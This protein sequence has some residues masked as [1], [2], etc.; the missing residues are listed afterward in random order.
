M[1]GK[2]ATAY[3]GSKGDRIT[4]LQLV[5]LVVPPLLLATMR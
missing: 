2:R 5:L 3:Q 1:T 4:G